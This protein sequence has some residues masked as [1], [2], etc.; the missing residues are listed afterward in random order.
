MAFVYRM[1]PYMR[2]LTHI[3]TLGTEG[4]FIWL[5]AQPKC[6]PVKVELGQKTEIQMGQLRPSN[7]YEGFNLHKHPQSFHFINYSCMVAR[8]CVYNV[9]SHGLTSNIAEYLG[10]AKKQVLWDNQRNNEW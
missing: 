5:R 7:Q 6:S 10:K 1:R 3:N 8:H 4:S 9:D 2:A